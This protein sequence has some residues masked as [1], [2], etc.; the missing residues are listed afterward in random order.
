[1]KIK[2]NGHASFTIT[3]NKGT[4]IVTDPYN[5]GKYADEFTYDIVRDRAD[6]ALVSH[7]HTDHS[8]VEGLSG[9]PKVLKGPGRIGDIEV[10]TINTYHDESGGSKRGINRVFFFAVD[11]INICFLGDLGHMLSQEQIKALGHVDVLLVPVGGYYTIDSRQASELIDK[12]KPKVAIPM[13]FKTKKCGFPIAGVDVFLALVKNEK[14]ADKSEVE[15]PSGGL[16]ETG[17][18]IWVMNYAC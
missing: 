14:K 2:W 4:V 7:E 9:S 8:Y 1:M 6:G 12:I 13:H 10:K 11:A 17:T 5:S 15:I 16:P 3:S 18:E